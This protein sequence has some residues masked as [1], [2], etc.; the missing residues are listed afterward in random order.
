MV[1]PNAYWAIFERNPSLCDEH[2][3]M[4][5]SLLYFAAD[6]P[7]KYQALYGSHRV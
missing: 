2:G 3:P 5:F 4:R 7:A 6:G 1:P